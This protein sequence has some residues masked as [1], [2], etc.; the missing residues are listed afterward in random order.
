M[1]DIKIQTN[2]AE[3]LDRLIGGDPKLEIEVKMQLY[4]TS[5]RSMSRL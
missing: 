2:S 5:E 1:S 4:R 3:A